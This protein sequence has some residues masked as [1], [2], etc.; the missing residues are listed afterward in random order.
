MDSRFHLRF[1]QISGIVSADL[2]AVVS[3]ELARFLTQNVAIVIDT[4]ISIV[5]FFFPFLRSRASS[6][7]WFGR[8]GG[9]RSCTSKGWSKIA[10]HCQRLSGSFWRVTVRHGYG[11]GCALN[12]VQHDQ[13][14]CTNSL[15]GPIRARCLSQETRGGGGGN[16]LNRGFGGSGPSENFSGNGLVACGMAAGL[17]SLRRNACRLAAVH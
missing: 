15:G 4:I 2:F 16:R 10:D 7:I 11:F 8:I 5:D 17:A 6:D 3:D 9:I 12:P 14:S 13:L 1:Q